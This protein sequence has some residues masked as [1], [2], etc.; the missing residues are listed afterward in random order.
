[1]LNFQ[2][3]GWA[4]PLLEAPPY[5]FWVL[6]LSPTS[7]HFLS[8]CVLFLFPF[9]SVFLPIATSP[10]LVLEKSDHRELLPTK[11]PLIL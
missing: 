10:A 7:L 9:L 5:I 8:P 1:M 2:P 4:S 3:R 6:L 11:P